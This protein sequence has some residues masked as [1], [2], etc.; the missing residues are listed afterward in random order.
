MSKGRD[1]LGLDIF[2][3]VFLLTTIITRFFTENTNL[4]AFF[5]FISFSVA[6][7]DIYAEIEIEYKD[8]GKRFFIVRGAFIVSGILCAVI[9]SVITMFGFAVDPLV[10]DE[11]SILA[12]LACLPK[13][14]YCYILR[15]YI[16]GW[17]ENG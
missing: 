2:M 7:Y 15:K 11:L 13:N 6:V 16:H 1:K 10:V 3:F 17:E 8:Y 12:L 14:L 5:A 9:V 4:F